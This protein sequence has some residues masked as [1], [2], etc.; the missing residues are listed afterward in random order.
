MVDDSAPSTHAVVTKPRKRIVLVFKRLDA[1]GGAEAMGRLLIRLFSRLGH[2]L[3]IIARKGSAP[4]EVSFLRVDPFHLGRNF[5]YSGYA[6]AVR[7]ACNRLMPDVIY[8]REHVPG[9][10][11]YHAGGGVHAEMFYQ[12]RRAEGR[13]KRTLDYWHPHH[14][15]RLRLERR[16]YASPELRA[17]ICNSAMVR[18]DIERRFGVP[19]TMLH[20]VENGIDTAYYSRGRDADAYRSGLRGE[21]GIGGDDFVLLFVGSGFHRKG[22]GVAIRALARAGAHARLVV[23][24]RDSSWRRFHRLATQLGVADRVHFVGGQ[25]DIRSWY[26]AADALIHPAL[27]EAYGLIVPEAMAAGLPVIASKR[28]GSALSLV[29]EGENGYMADALDTEGFSEAIDALADSDHRHTLG[30]AAARRAKLHDV[31]V[32][33]ERFTTVLEELIAQIAATSATGSQASR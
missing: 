2:D 5:R 12:T 8:S 1:R 21:L 23:V 19:R 15:G 14:R 20:V 32:L 6:R 10:H 29:V 30:V 22:V 9:C 27:Y 25:S 31:N 24:G 11:I 26:W 33:R 16:M 4:S 17:V 3:T 18:D 7:R 28:C 13:L